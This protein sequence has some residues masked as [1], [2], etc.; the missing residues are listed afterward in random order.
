MVGAQ[1]SRS[2]TMKKVI[3][4]EVE[5]SKKGGWGLSLGEFH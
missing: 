1:V 3:N 5:W 2:L 4:E